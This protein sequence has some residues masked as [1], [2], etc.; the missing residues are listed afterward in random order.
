MER[1][2]ADRL[3]TV[4]KLAGCGICKDTGGTYRAGPAE[5]VGDQPINLVYLY[6]KAMI[7]KALEGPHMR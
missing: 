5:G 7:Q 2:A 1:G 3:D 4:P 6:P